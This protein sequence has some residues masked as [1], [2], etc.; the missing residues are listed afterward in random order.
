LTSARLSAVEDDTAI[1]RRCLRKYRRQLH[2]Q[3]QIPPDV[4]EDS[5]REAA[6]TRDDLAEY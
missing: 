4:S 2:Q 3:G 1:V 5:C 6:R